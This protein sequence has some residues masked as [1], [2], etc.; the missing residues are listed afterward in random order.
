MKSDKKNLVKTLS[1]NALFMTAFEMIVRYGLAIIVLPIALVKFESE[2]LAYYLFISTLVALAFLADSGFSQTII[3]TA[4]YFRAGAK[5]IPSRITS[6]DSQSSETSVNWHALGRLV[7]TSSR[8]YSVVSIAAAI[9]L[10]TLGIFAANNVISQQSNK[11]TAWITYFLI[12]CVSIFLLQVS[13]WTALMQGLNQVATAKRIEFISGI[14]RLFGIATAI[15]VGSGVLGVVIVMLTAAM[16]TTYIMRSL[17]L[18]T[19]QVNGLEKKDLYVYDKE[20]FMELWPS[21]W[22]MAGICWGGYLIYYGTSLIIS[23]IPDAKLIASYLLTFQVVT[24]LYRFST[25]PAMA[26]QPQLAA[27]MS[28]G[29]LKNVQY[30]SL[31]ILKLALLLYIGGGIVTYFFAEDMLFLIKSKTHLISSDIFLLM[32]VMYFF[33]LHHSIHA[34]I[35]LNSNHVPF[36]IPSIIS[37]LSIMISGFLFMKSYGIYA[38][39]WSQFLVQACFNNWYPVFLSLRLQQMPFKTYMKNIFRFRFRPN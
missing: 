39:V 32:L 25:S 21:T 11:I 27:A 23:Q 22:R 5:K 35:Y 26:F 4:S 8:I 18:K 29:D 14:A 1:N 2:E 3:R 16:V 34:G 33:E 6:L 13:R 24:L 19:M 38:V 9:L 28:S 7:A 31:K 20:M 37:G 17:V 15:F 30:F 10:F 12:V 36:L